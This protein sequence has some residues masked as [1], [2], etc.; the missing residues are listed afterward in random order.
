MP[1][2]GLLLCIAILLGVP[3]AVKR[4]RDL[5]IDREFAY[6]YLSLTVVVALLGANSPTRSLRPGRCL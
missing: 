4:T 5:R 2:Y 1:T 3:L 6:A